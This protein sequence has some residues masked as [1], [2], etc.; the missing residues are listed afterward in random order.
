MQ[1]FSNCILEISEK[2][3]TDANFQQG[4]IVSSVWSL[5][6]S[7]LCHKSPVIVQGATRGL[8]SLLIRQPRLFATESSTKIVR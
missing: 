4:A 1:T 3:F 7:N 2:I 8:G 6:V 5:F